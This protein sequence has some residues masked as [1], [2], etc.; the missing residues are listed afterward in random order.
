MRPELVALV[1]KQ[2][3]VFLRRQALACGYSA[4][5]VRIA[6]R[7]RVWV[8][9]RRGAYAEA[10]VV[11]GSSG[12]ERHVLRVRAV[13][14]A[15]EEPWAVSHNSAALVHELPTWGTDLSAVHMTRTK[16]HGARTEAGVKHHLATLPSG[17]LVIA[18][19]ILTTGLA[20]TAT[21]VAR[22]FGREPGVVCMDAALGRGVSEA[23]MHRVVEELGQWPGACAA[24]AAASVADGRAESPGE[25]RTRLLVAECGLP[26]PRLQAVV[27][28]G[29]F[30]AR[31]DMLIDEYSLII[32]FDGRAKYGRGRD[33]VDARVSD[34]DLVWAEKLREDR[35]RELGFEVVRL[36]W[37]D[38]E[39]PRRALAKRR[40]LDAAARGRRRVQQR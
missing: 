29:D 16:V 11:D 40:L 15:L 23:K 33:G 39:G 8:P 35:L 36:V 14:L 1:A 6:L 10:S 37:A 9:I 27:T 4:Q 12:V 5:E 26:A 18:G 19:G 7:R 17:S 20:R 30:A 21:D 28:D 2:G 32:E 24:K 25:S 34:G 22:E 3:G 31:V 13:S 38:L